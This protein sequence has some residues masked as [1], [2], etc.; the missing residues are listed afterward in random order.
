MEKKSMKTRVRNRKAKTTI[1]KTRTKGVKAYTQRIIG[2][3]N[4]HK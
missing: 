2:G 4:H 3:F 1:Y